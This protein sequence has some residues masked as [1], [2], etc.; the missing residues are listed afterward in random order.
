VSGQSPEEAR[1]DGKIGF[2]FQDMKLL[3]FLS[4]R[5]NLAW[6]QR[7][8]RAIGGKPSS[9]SDVEEALD[10][11]GLQR[12]ASVWPK[13]LSGG[14]RARVA[15]ARALITKPRLLLLD[16]ALASLDIGWRLHLHRELMALRDRLQ[17]TIFMISHD[18]EEVTRM[19]DRVV[20]LSSSGAI[21]G[22]LPRTGNKGA[23]L[24]QMEQLIMRDHPAQEGAA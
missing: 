6:A 18:L 22:V 14:M 21:A 1:R 7:Q 3:P 12:Q 20:V 10:L 2:V 4:A 23:K 15:L 24:R 11:V 5:E 19:A 9:P 17:L 8:I 16:E 13:E